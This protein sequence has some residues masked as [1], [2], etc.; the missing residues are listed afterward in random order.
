MSDDRATSGDNLSTVDHRV[1]HRSTI[2]AIRG[3][4][5]N[6]FVREKVRAAAPGGSGSS[7]VVLMI[8]GGYSPAIL[9][10]DV[11]VRDYSWMSFLARA[12]IRAFAM[13]MSGYG[14]SIHPPMMDDPYNLPPEQQ[15]AL[16]LPR[17]RKP[18]YP[19]EL[20]N[21]DSEADD[22]D[23]AVDFI[24]ARC[25]VGKLTLIGWSG[26]GFRAGTYASRHPEKVEKLIIFASSN[27]RR[28]GPSEPTSA[29]PKPGAALTIQTR[30]V[31]EGRR[32]LGTARDMSAIDA[33]MPQLIWDCMRRLDPVGATWGPGGLRAPSRTYWG[34]NAQA[35]ATISLPTLIMV[36]EQD[37][38]LASNLDLY[39]DLRSSHK[40]FLRIAGATHFM[41]WE[42]QSRVLHRASLEWLVSGAIEGRESGAFMADES[43]AVSAA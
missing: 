29:I 17:T 16:G 2:P 14:G 26:G 13:D 39:D 7:P 24:R 15:A 35:A 36:G 27:Y 32:W 9:A 30:D 11:P 33:D 20:V 8:H 22:I 37:A 23:R 3:E 43:G 6:L 5:V 4:S 31:S 28:N 38:L 1:A 21:A 41:G 12:G 25:G 40:A 42:R 18:S 34:W 19:F 10:F